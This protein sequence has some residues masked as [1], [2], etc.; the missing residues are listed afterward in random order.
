MSGEA[1]QTASAIALRKA[2]REQR[3]IE[4]QA[5]T[6]Y[7]VPRAEAKRARR[8]QVR[9]ENELRTR[10]GISE[11]RLGLEIRARRASRQRNRR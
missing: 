2:R 1:A 5:Q 6:D 7:K 3:A 9:V 10:R 8:R 4:R 11:A